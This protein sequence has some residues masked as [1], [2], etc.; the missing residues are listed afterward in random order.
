VPLADDGTREKTAF[1]SSSGVYC[2]NRLP[3]GLM[4][5]G[6]AFAMVMTQVLRDINF[7]FAITYVDD[8]CVFSKDFEEHLEH[9]GKVFDRIE[10]AGLKLKPSKCKFAAPKVLYI[11]HI[12]SKQGVEVDPDKS[13]QVQSYPQPVDQK[14]IRAFLGLA[15]YYRRFIKDF[16]SIATPLNQLLH[17]DTTFVWSVKCQQ[18]FDTLKQ[19]LVAPPVLVYPDFKKEFTVYTDASEFSI[20]YVLGQLDDA[21]NE[22]VICYGGRTLR[23]TEKNWHITELEGLA[24]IEAIKRYRVYLADKHFRIVTDHEALLALKTGTHLKK[25]LQRWALY[26]SQYDYE[27][28]H[29]AG[30]KHCNADAL[31]RRVYQHDKSQI[32]ENESTDDIETCNISNEKLIQYYE[33]EYPNLKPTKPQ[34]THQISVIDQTSTKTDQDCTT[35][36]NMGSYNLAKPELYGKIRYHK[37][38]ETCVEKSLSLIDVERKLTKCP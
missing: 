8:I 6:N 17:K 9:L 37:P 5:A 7:R 16:A 27:I 23:Q 13:A 20:G 14:G 36:N 25:R 12:F 3:F 1:W 35:T 10:K 18:A 28:C 15:G 4:N 2:F 24:V 22:R 32:F 34:E 19:C 38:H 33:I 30:A 11:G 21:G 26:L 29:R 31:S